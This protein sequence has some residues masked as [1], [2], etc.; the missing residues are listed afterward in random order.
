VPVEDVSASFADVDDLELSVPWIVGGQIIWSPPVAGLRLGYSGYVGDVEA[1]GEFRYDVLVDD[2]DA[3]PSYLPYSLAFDQ[4][5]DFTETHTYSLEYVRSGWTLASELST[6]GIGSETSLGWYVSNEYRFCSR[7]SVAGVFSEFFPDKDD[8]DGVE[9]VA[10]GELDH[11]AW[12]RDY[13]ISLRADINE[14]WLVKLEFHAMD[15]SAMVLEG[16]ADASTDEDR[17]WR[18]LAAKTTFHF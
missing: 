6:T 18:M 15:G 12:Q 8:R 7:W 3:I 16:G 1:Y 5:L 4:D 2:G 10:A 11:H 13:C 14:H 9:Q 17:Y